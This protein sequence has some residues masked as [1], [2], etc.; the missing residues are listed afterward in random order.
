MTEIDYFIRHPYRLIK[1]IRGRKMAVPPSEAVDGKFIK[2][3]SIVN[4]YLSNLDRGR[5]YLSAPYSTY[6]CDDWKSDKFDPFQHEDCKTCKPFDTYFEGYDIGFLCGKVNKMVVIDNDT[7]MDTAKFRDYIEKH[8]GSLPETWT[9]R[10]SSGGQ[11]YYYRY[12]GDLPSDISNFIP[13]VDFISNNRWVALPPF[14][15]KKGKY[16][17]IIPPT[18]KLAAML[19]S[20]VLNSK[21]KKLAKTPER[22]NQLQLSSK[23]DAVR[24]REILS[25]WNIQGVSHAHWLAVGQAL[26]PDYEKEFLDWCHSDPDKS[27]ILKSRQEEWLKANSGNTGLGVFFTIAKECGII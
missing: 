20:W 6:F 5:P 1:I 8:Y 24:I 26:Y 4:N 27:R 16:E 17:W 14:E 12:D 3:E 23:E 15:N 18:S 10:T 25:R 22:S 2:E 11:H 9:A 19:P 13:K 7:G 21:L